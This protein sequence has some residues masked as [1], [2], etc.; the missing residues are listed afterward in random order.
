M[1]LILLQ[2]DFGTALVFFPLYLTMAYIGGVNR[3]YL[4]MIVAI[5]AIAIVMTVMPIW[6][7]VTVA[8][9]SILLRVFY[10][11][12]YVYYIVLIIAS[13]L[14]LSIA[15]FRLFKRRY[16]YWTAYGA[17][18]LVA[19][20]AASLVG[21]RLLKE[22]QVMRWPSFWIPV[23]IHLDQAGTFCNLSRR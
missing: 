2:P 1:G 9:P 22:Y 18:I 17:L 13:T 8:K 14:G 21:Q 15:G 5:G 16:Y 19:G 3:R 6:Q 20:I 23:S 12:P 10:E 4:F 7:T 11:K